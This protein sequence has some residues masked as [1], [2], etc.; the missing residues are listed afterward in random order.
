[1]AYNPRW[2]A[3]IFGKLFVENR[4][5][6]LS[7]KGTYQILCASK[8]I[9]ANESGLEMESLVA[10]RKSLQGLSSSLGGAKSS[11]L[12]DEPIFY[13]C[14]C[15]VGGA[16]SGAVGLEWTWMHLLGI[17]LEN[18]K[19]CCAQVLMCIALFLLLF[20]GRWLTSSDWDYWACFSLQ[21]VLPNKDP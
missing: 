21:T 19:P 16:S 18:A 4:E 7:R 20:A 2:R 10:G 14:V 3:W 17:W 5:I 8:T 11:A 15:A 6:N 9:L 13:V 12:P 1:M